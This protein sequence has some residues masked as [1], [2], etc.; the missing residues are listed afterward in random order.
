MSTAA[1]PSAKGA[2]SRIIFSAS[3]ARP[4][5]HPVRS[6]WRAGDLPGQ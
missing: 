5:S 3:P 4:T 6:P 1:Q 2:T